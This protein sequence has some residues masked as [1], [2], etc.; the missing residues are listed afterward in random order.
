MYERV[1]GSEVCLECGESLLEVRSLSIIFHLQ[2]NILGNNLSL[3]PGSE[4]L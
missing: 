4:A 3:D 2:T 1:R